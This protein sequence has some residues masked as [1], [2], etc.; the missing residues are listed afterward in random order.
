VD[1]GGTLLQSVPLHITTGQSSSEVFFLCAA[2][3]AAMY[4]IGASLSDVGPAA[5]AG[6]ASDAGVPTDGGMASTSPSVNLPIAR[7]ITVGLSALTQGFLAERSGS[8]YLVDALYCGGKQEPAPP[9]LVRVS[10]A[11]NVTVDGHVV[12][13]CDSSVM[14]EDAGSTSSSSLA[15]SLDA[16]LDCRNVTLAP[17]SGGT[18]HLEISP[19]H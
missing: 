1:D 9:D 8:R 14:D 18:C 4:Q 6:T 5:D 16:A 11:P 10:G 19:G 2:G 7:P 13:A 15:S 3:N 12:I 17:T